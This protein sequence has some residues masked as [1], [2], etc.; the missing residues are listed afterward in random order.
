MQLVYHHPF[1]PKTKNRNEF[2]V[3]TLA[4]LVHKINE[5][6]ITAQHN[7]FHLLLLFVFFRF[8]FLPSSIPSIPPH[9]QT[10]YIYN[11]TECLFLLSSV[12][13]IYRFCKYLPGI[14]Y[15]VQ[16]YIPEKQQKWMDEWINGRLE[17]TNFF[18]MCARG[19]EKDWNGKN[20]DL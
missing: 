11:A 14:L 20:R 10:Q 18:F 9:T 15:T 2:I 6:L 8:F 3:L 19:R 17:N 12:I 1:Q 7:I 16:I 5:L 13:S 4:C